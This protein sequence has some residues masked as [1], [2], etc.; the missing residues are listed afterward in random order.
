MLDIPCRRSRER[1]YPQQQHVLWSS[2]DGVPIMRAEVKDVSDSGL[3]LVIAR[4]HQPSLGEAISIVT[5]G[6]PAPR[7]ARVLRVSSREDGRVTVGCRWISN[8]EHHAVPV[9]TRRRRSHH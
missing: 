2:H 4:Q 1:A 3:G 8:K 9:S 6:E 7:R 5:T